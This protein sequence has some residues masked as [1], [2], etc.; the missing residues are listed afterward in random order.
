MI[1]E[2]IPFIILLSL[3]IIG[4]LFF[5]SFWHKNYPKISIALA[6]IVFL[7][8]VQFKNDW[9]SP[10]ISLFEYFSFVIF[11]SALFVISGGI[12]IHIDK[13]STPKLNIIFLIIGSLT[14]NLIGTT[15]AAM[16]LIRPYIR[17]NKYHL[18]PFHIVFFIFTICNLGGSLTPIGDPPLI[19]GFFKGVP[20]FF[21]ILNIAPY[22]LLAHVLLLGI[23]WILEFRNKTNLETQTIEE[24]NKIYLSGKRNIFWILLIILSVF[25][26]PSTVSWVPYIQIGHH[27]ISFVRELIQLLII[28]LCYSFR[29]K[30]AYQLN[31]FSLAPL[32]EIV[33]LFIGIFIT[34]VPVLNLLS[35]W[36]SKSGADFINTSS[37]YW[38]SGIFSSL[39][40]NAPTY[41]CFLTAAMSKSGLDIASSKDVMLF[42]NGLQMNQLLA[43]SIGAV[44]FGAMTYIGNGPNFMVKSIAEEKD[45][46]M[47]NFVKY[48][49]HYTIPY[50]LPV[51]IAVYLL[52][53]YKYN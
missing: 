24:S 36:S 40:D 42:A 21:T 49:T 34:M 6:L 33:F 4:P 23:F 14:S 35:T 28:Y 9:E 43:I 53:I 16:L 22:W 39:L 13:N 18:K 52:L 17:F 46:K 2:S 44:F 19:L 50:L 27:H 37:L 11:L 38:F 47:P 30:N 48:I 5:A 7:Y 1:L 26:N 32:K 15:G 45:I 20:F 41:L 8:F 3:V 25:V 29:D 31:E 10:V 51:L 12:Y